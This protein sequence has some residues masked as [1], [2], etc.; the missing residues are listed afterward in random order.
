MFFYRPAA[1]IASATA[2]KDMETIRSSVY[3]GD[4]VRNIHRWAAHLMVFSVSLHMARVFYT[5]AYKPPREFNW[6]VGVILLFLTLGL[7]FTGYL[8]PWDQLSVWAVAGG[9]DRRIAEGRARRAAALAY[10]KVHGEPERA[11]RPA[12]AGATA[13]AAPGDGGGNGGA[14]PATAP[15]AA[16]VA[17]PPGGMYVP[18]PAAAVR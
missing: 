11:P 9:A 18:P 14:A 8:L 6:V 3:F 15:A 12:P 17:A 7:S 2:Y 10:R 5:G 4:L 1:D 16:A 13:G